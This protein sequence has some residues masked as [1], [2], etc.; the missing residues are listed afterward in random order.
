MEIGSGSS[1]CVVED[2]VACLGLEL[3]VVAHHK[4]NVGACGAFETVDAD[5]VA[6]DEFGAVVGV[7]YGTVLHRADLEAYRATVGSCRFFGRFVAART[8]KEC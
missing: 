8:H 2:A 3:P 5:A 6:G 4:G 7:G 1:G